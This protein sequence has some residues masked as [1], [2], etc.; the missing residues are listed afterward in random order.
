MA[1]FGDSEKMLEINGKLDKSDTCK[2]FSSNIS[3]FS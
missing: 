1:D 2:R 3:F